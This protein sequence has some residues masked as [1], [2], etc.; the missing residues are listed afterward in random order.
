VPRTELESAS[1]EAE[2][3]NVELAER[4]RELESKLSDSTPKSELAAAET[5][6]QELQRELSESKKNAESL[7]RQLAELT[8][9]LPKHT[10]TAED[11]P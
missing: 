9:H 1:A 6:I 10:E 4:V 5:K 11:Q 7:E 8:A 2:A 3:K